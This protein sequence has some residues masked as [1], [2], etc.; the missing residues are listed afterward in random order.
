MVQECIGCCGARYIKSA[1]S[2]PIPDAPMD[3]SAGTFRAD[4]DEANAPIKALCWTPN[5][6]WYALP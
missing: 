5:L 3:K 6:E 2:S 4:L 1:I